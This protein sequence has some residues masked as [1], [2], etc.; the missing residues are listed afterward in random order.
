[1]TKNLYRA[2]KKSGRLGS[3][4]RWEQL[5]HSALKKEAENRKMVFVGVGVSFERLPTGDTKNP[6][7]SQ[8]WQTFQ[9]LPG[10]ATDPSR[11]PQ[12]VSYQFKSPWQTGQQFC[13]QAVFHT[14]LPANPWDRSFP[15]SLHKLQ[16]QSRQKPALFSHLEPP[17]EEPWCPLESQSRMGRSF[18]EGVNPEKAP[19][20]HSSNPHSRE[21]TFS[22]GFRKRCFYKNRALKYRAMSF[23]CHYFSINYQNYKCTL[24]AMV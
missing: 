21:L 11:S 16:D 15:T 14:F 12:I 20:V 23:L 24:W 9:A 4:E 6:S 19:V 3:I 10:S 8:M 17:C 5:T 2:F 13:F 18:L 7:N 22:G 1:M